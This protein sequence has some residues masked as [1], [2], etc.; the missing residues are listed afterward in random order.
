MVILK[1]TRHLYSDAVLGVDNYVRTR[2]RI[3]TQFSTMSEKFK[4]KMIEFSEPSSSN[5][6]FT[7]DLKNMVHLV[8]KDSSD[9]LN[10]VIKM[11]RR[12]TGNVLYFHDRKGHY[13]C[14]CCAPKK[15]RENGQQNIQSD[16]SHQGH[17]SAFSAEQQAAMQM[18]AVIIED[19]WTM[20]SGAFAHMTNYCDYFS[21]FEETVD[22]TSVV[23]GNNQGLSVRGRFN[24]QN[25]DLRFGNFVFGPVVMRMFYYMNTP[26]AA[27]EVFK[28]PVM[29]GFFDQLISYQLLMDLLFINNRFSDILDNTKESFELAMDIWRELQTVGHIPLRR[30]A[31]FAAALALN[32][33]SP[34][35]A[36]EI[37]STVRQQNYITIRNIK[38]AALADLGRVD[39]ALPILRSILLVDDPDQRKQSVTEDVPFYKQRAASHSAGPGKSIWAP[40]LTSPPF[41][42]ITID[43]PGKACWLLLSSP[44]TLSRACLKCSE[45]EE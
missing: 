28:D 27:L 26:E 17:F 10:L 33:N 16:R 12:K 22:N 8:E 39:D 9:D 41:T 7:E 34:Q 42:H 38:M 6:I 35:Y 13:M 3:Q 30:S 18:L 19:N 21:K 25:K 20:D 24:Q 43:S 23:L 31:T 5:M 40:P 32:Q 4:S 36:L 37:I 15:P 14:D 1:G 45:V 11:L 2:E 44:L 29:D